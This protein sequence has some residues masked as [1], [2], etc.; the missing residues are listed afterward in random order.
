MYARVLHKLIGILLILPFI[1]WIGTGAVFL[2]KP[3]YESAYST[4]AVK[5]YEI[6]AAH[7]IAPNPAWREY[8]MMRTILGDHLLVRRGKTWVH[9]NPVT[10]LPVDR[11]DDVQVKLLLQDAANQFP[12][13]YGKIVQWADGLYI[14]STGVELSLDW[15]T[16]T[17]Q[18][19]GRDTRLINL[20]YRIHYL[21]WFG[22]EQDSRAFGI[23]GLGLLALLLICGLVLLFLPA[24]KQP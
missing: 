13:R 4:L 14:T 11:P 15:D 3:G 16:L 5:K 1:G 19:K 2:L 10:Y 18:Q 24:Q 7:K 20:L 8:R 22:E 12:S 21:Q 17:I 6:T 23:A 9:F